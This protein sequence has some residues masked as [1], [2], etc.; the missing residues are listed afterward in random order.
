MKSRVDRINRENA[1]KFSSFDDLSLA[2]LAS[3]SPPSAS[4]LES[5]STSH[6]D[7]V[8]EANTSADPYEN[9][10]LSFHLHGFFYDLIS[11]Y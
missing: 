8:L 7:V 3:A 6:G 1:G 5:A 2:M 9:V 11:Q 10:S 4:Q